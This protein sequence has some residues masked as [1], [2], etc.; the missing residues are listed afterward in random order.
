MLN[1]EQKAVVDSTDSKILVLAGAGTGKTHCMLERINH[2]I[3]NG[4]SAASMLVLTFT[5]AAALEMKTR[6]M[7]TQV[8]FRSIPPEFRTFHAFCYNLL[9][10]DKAILRELGYTSLPS[11]ITGDELD[12]LHKELILQLKLHLSLKKLTSGSALSRQDKYELTI[13]NK[14]KDKTLK[15]KNLIT[16]DLLCSQVC[17][18]FEA[19]S[20]LVKTYKDRYKYIFVDE[21]QDTDPI[22]WNFVRSFIPDSNI[23]VVGDAL[24]AIYSF[25]RADSTIIKNLAHMVYWKCY[26]LSRN[27]RSTK[28]ICDYANS[29][30][31]SEEYSVALVSDREGPAVTEKTYLHDA[32][33][34][35]N[36]P[37]LNQIKEWLK[38]FEGSSAILCRTNMEIAKLQAWLD[39]E[40]ISYSTKQKPCD[41]L[42][43]LN[44]IMDNEYLK[45]WLATF[46][47]AEE[48]TTFIK[49]DKIHQVEDGGYS[50]E[51]FIKDFAGSSSVLKESAQKV[52]ECREMLANPNYDARLKFINLSEKLHIPVPRHHS[53]SNM[54][55]NKEIVDSFI[56]LYMNVDSTDSSDSTD[57]Y[58]GTIH[59]VKGLEYDNVIVLNANGYSFPIYRGDN[60]NLFY[61]AVTRAKTNLYVMW[62]KED[63]DE[64]DRYENQ[65]PLH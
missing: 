12:K 48:Y 18:L 24:Q 32:F 8:K 6:F 50:C 16:F 62:T 30:S 38:T 25:R 56:T 31:K 64:E 41:T 27:Y 26:K 60:L 14:A 21:F 9:S 59:S 37:Q 61:V 36:S 29:Y 46:L 5:N 33:D 4:A 40:N 43:V 3:D 20:P 23:Y 51:A 45:N 28:Q 7:N 13:F 58:V 15:Q 19:D 11:I 10:Q 52:F 55:T 2:L 53:I 1:E 65:Q 47:S 42:S 17:K 39:S 35:P 63:D 57:L 22:Q 49:S 44:S 54:E 34:T